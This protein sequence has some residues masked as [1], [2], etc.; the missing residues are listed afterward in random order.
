[1]RPAPFVAAVFLLVPSV[2]LMAQGQASPPEPGARLRLT[3]PCELTDP[4]AAGAERTAC[5]LDGTLVRL[6]AD[7]IT[8]AVAQSITGYGLNAISR[9][10]VSRGHRSQWLPGAG[11]GFLVGAGVAW[12][13]LNGGGSTSPCDRS[14]NQ[15]AIG[16]GACIG[17]AAL[18][19]LAGAGLGAVIGGRVRTERWQDVPLEHL[20]ISLT[21]QA[22][23]EF[24][25]ALAVV[26]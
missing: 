9:V 21:P 1:M 10:E 12:V 2:T 18:G 26:F 14:A 20:R 16:S 13:L 6:G 8:L 19:G 7:T 11:V 4:R 24:G 5:R 17:L 15:D 3:L 22:G 23:R 25:L